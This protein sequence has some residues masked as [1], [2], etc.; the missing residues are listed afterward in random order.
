MLRA[1]RGRSTRGSKQRGGEDVILLCAT[2][3]AQDGIESGARNGGHG[4]AKWELFSGEQK[5]GR[6]SREWFFF[7][8]WAEPDAGRDSP[9]SSRLRPQLRLAKRQVNGGEKGKGVWE[10]GAGRQGLKVK[11]QT[12][13]WRGAGRSVGQV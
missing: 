9:P 10:H 2:R 12:A 11:P 1:V 7:L 5:Q 3:R 6:D 13:G 8:P 4:P